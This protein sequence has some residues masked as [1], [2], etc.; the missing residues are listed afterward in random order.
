[1]A[2]GEERSGRRKKSM[3]RGEERSGRRKKST[4][5]NRQFVKHA[6]IR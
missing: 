6:K 5:K 2:R 1:M 4:V 3:A